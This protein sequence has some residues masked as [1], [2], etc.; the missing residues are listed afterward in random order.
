MPDVCLYAKNDDLIFCCST[1]GR[2]SVRCVGGAR[3]CAPSDR[4]VLK[5]NSDPHV[6]R[7]QSA[8]FDARADQ[9]LV[10]FQ[11]CTGSHFDGIS[12]KLQLKAPAGEE[13]ATLHGVCMISSQKRKQLMSDFWLSCMEDQREGIGPIYSTEHKSMLSVVDN[14]NQIDNTVFWKSII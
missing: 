14:F 5:V 7:R 4:S 1:C 10:F 8:L 3:T 12:L 9:L 2:Y 6:S 13:G 11:T